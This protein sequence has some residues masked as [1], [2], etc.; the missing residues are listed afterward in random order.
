MRSIFLQKLLTHRAG[1][2][3]KRHKKASVSA[4]KA[5]KGRKSSEKAQKNRT[6]PPRA[7]TSTK[8][9]SCPDPRRKRNMAHPTARQ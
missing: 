1:R 9:R 2:Q 6:A 7:P 4:Q 3:I 5:H 8:P